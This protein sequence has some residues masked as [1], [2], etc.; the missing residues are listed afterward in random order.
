MWSESVELDEHGRGKIDLYKHF[1]SQEE[2][3][4]TIPLQDVPWEISLQ[5]IHVVQKRSGKDRLP[6]LGYG[7]EVLCSHSFHQHRNSIVPDTTLYNTLGVFHLDDIP[8]GYQIVEPTNRPRCHVPGA[9]GYLQY[10]QR[11]CFPF[12]AHASP[13]VDVWIAKPQ[14][15][16]TKRASKQNFE[17]FKKFEM[18]QRKFSVSFDWTVLRTLANLFSGKAR[19]PSFH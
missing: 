4:K 14:H 5:A 12:Q 8:E 17:K 3:E 6:S 10:G 13:V 16:A 15:K 11:D 18:F 1:K 7:I 9:T 19:Y 2:V